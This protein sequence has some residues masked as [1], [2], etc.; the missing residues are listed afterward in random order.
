[1]WALRPFSGVLGTLKATYRVY[2]GYI[3]DPRVKGPYW[4]PIASTL[5]GLGLG[6]RGWGLGL[7]AQV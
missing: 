4:G 1:M 7:G 3:K 6:F 5:E 2:S